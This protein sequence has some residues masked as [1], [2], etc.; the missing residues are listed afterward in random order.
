MDAI[1]GNVFQGLTSLALEQFKLLWSAKHDVESMKN[2]IRAIRATLLDAEAS[3]NDSHEVRLWLERLKDV[4]YDADDLL[5]DLSTEA[6]RRGIMTGNKVAKKVRIFF[7]KSNQVVFNF[8]MAYKL[9]EVRGRLDEIDNDKKRFYLMDHPPKPLL[10]LE[11]RK[12]TYSVVQDEIIGRKEETVKI[13]SYLLDSNVKSSVSII[14]IVGFGGL[15]KTALAQVVYNHVDVQ[16]HFGLKRWVCVSE[17]FNVKQVAQKILGQESRKNLEQVQQELRQLIEGKKFLIVL[18]DVW[19]ED[20]E[21]WDKL[22][23]LL[24]TGVEGSMIIVTTRSEK[25]GNMMNETYSPIIL[26][27]LDDDRSWELFCRMAFEGGRE[28]NNKEMLK[29]GIDVV[30]KCG[31]V[32]LAIRAVGRLVY[33]KILEGITD[34]SYLR[35]SELWNIDQLE[36]RIF[37]VLK[38]SYDHLPSPMKNCIAFCSLFPKGFLFHTQTLIRMWVAEGFIQSTNKRCKEDLGNEYF[39]NLLSR[40]FFQDVK[41]GSS[42]D[43]VG[44]KMHDLIHD[45]AQFI[46]KD[47]YLLIKEEKAKSTKDTIR[48]LAYD[49]PRENWE[50]PT[51]FLE[52][53]KL[54]TMLLFTHSFSSQMDHPVFDLLASKLKFLRVLDLGSSFMN[55][56]PKSI[57][58]LKHLR[59]LDLSCNDIKQ[60][61]RTITKLYNLQSLNLSWNPSIR[62]LPKDVS[63][64]VSLRHLN[65]TGCDGLEWMPSGLRQLTSLQTLTNFVVDN[66]EMHKKRA[67]ARISELSELN[68]L[69]GIL[70]ISGLKHLRSNPEEAQSA[71]LKEKER[72]Q[73]LSL[74][75]DPLYSPSGEISKDASD[76]LILERLR[77]HHTIKCLVIE[78]FCGE[79]LPDWIGNLMELRYL[80]LV[81]CWHLTSLPEG[82]RNLA[83]LQSLRIHRCPSFAADDI[84][85]DFARIPSVRIV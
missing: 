11:E 26:E 8:K 78:R 85:Q 61:P 17:E 59:F 21:I 13:L 37:T 16:K 5:D 6:L 43:I 24:T 57:G 9:R 30:K 1:A 48:H 34:L 3:A 44:C 77:P 45:L 51:S 38:L 54:R 20:V 27:G 23:C 22:K 62:E 7:S 71:R 14:P 80:E 36:K 33:D 67:S 39:M 56:I 64:L 25:V 84:R 50:V 41:R 53:E 42:G 74:C 32:P 66:R 65:L 58:K 60:V 83:S 82:L 47:E 69:R 15:G 81:D 49:V 76:E 79:R 2:T 12:Q 73:Q 46:A 52:F 18:D 75:W 31:G 55:K 35:N 72:L 28:S 29:I 63:E 70:R 68:N 19:N 10:V 40:S 4:L